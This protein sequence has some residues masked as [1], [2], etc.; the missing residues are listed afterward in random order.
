MPITEAQAKQVQQLLEQRCG[1]DLHSVGIKRIDKA[2]SRLAEQIGGDFQTFFNELSYDNQLLHRLIDQ[3]V[4]PETYFFRY[5]QSYELLRRWAT[6]WLK[7]NPEG[8]L[9]VASIP[10]ATG[11]EPYSIAMILR[12]CGFDWGRFVI[13]AVDVS[14]PLIEYSRQGL[15]HPD[16]LRRHPLVEQARYFDSSAAGIRVKKELRDSV[17]FIHGNVTKLPETFFRAPYPLVFCRNVLIYLSNDARDA[18][19]QQIQK[20]MSPK[21]IL[22][23]GPP[24]VSFFLGQGMAVMSHGQAFALQFREQPRATPKPFARPL[25]KPLSRLTGQRGRALKPTLPELPLPIRRPSALVAESSQMATSASQPAQNP[26]Q[27]VRALADSGDLEAAHQLL[28]RQ[29]QQS[30]D[31]EGFLLEGEI[32]LAKEDL[33]GSHKALKKALYLD[34][35]N[36][37]ALSHLCLLAQRLGN[38][39][40]A[41]KYRLRL[42]SLAE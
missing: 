14:G 28:S 36:R 1:W 20:I 29:L 5:P 12:D 10:S 26:L 16:S 2:T 35:S 8:C 38:L 17:N 40:E 39:A 6:R 22:F 15:Y 7:D 34:P 13:D 42:K 31:V 30:R 27:Q 21:G 4:I 9:R 25:L 33:T 24:E 37:E 18:L 41:K 11:E 3:L 19:Y 23:T 32:L